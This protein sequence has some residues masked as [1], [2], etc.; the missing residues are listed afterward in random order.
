VRVAQHVHAWPVLLVMMMAAPE[1]QIVE[2]GGTCRVRHQVVGLAPCC[3]D[4]ATRPATA[5]V[6]H[7]QRPVLVVAGEPNDV[8]K[9]EDARPCP[10][11]ALQ[12]SVL[13]E[14]T[15]DAGRNAVAVGGAGRCV[16][17]AK[18]RLDVEHQQHCRT[19]TAALHFTLGQRIAQHDEPIGQP[20]LGC[21]FVTLARCAA[22][23]LMAFMNCRDCSVGRV[24]VVVTIPSSAAPERTERR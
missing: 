15:C 13:G 14:V 23:K 4:L 2:R 21:A 16:G 8:A 22:T 20:L 17:L 11:D 10:G 12:V 1:H 9:I 18:V 5:A 7:E 19:F 3:R 24:T 6:A